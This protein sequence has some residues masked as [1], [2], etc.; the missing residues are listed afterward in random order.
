MIE[1]I[2]EPRPIRYRKIRPQCRAAII[3]MKLY[4][5]VVDGVWD[6]RVVRQEGNENDRMFMSVGMLVEMRRMVE[7]E[8]YWGP[9]VIRRT[10]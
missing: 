5:V 9:I 10:R 1:V 3:K 2:V 8:E 7:I 6:G 4:P